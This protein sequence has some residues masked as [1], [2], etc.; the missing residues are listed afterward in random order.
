MSTTGA[1][2]RWFRDHFG[3]AEMAAEASGGQNAY[4][5]L[6]DLAAS[7]PAGSQGLVCLPYLSG[8]RTPI[9]DPLARGIYAGLTLSHTRAH[10]YRASLEGTAYGVRDNLDVMAAM[11]ADPK[12][13]VAVGGGA[14]NPLWL[15]IVSD[16]SG[17]AQMVPE[18]TIG[19]SY[20][21]AFLA[22]VATG[23]I[24]DRN[25]INT[26][27]V[28]IDRIVEPAP[29]MKPVYEPYYEIYRSLYRSTKTE[30]HQLAQLGQ[31]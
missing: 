12:R 29:S 7:V 13:I 28:T 20:G 14:S 4:Q 2:T 1:L 5:A 17:K 8:E 27:W 18:R 3:Q 30:M 10:L 19:A 31:Y 23:I 26:D 25:A 6:A 11:G 24:K 9:N 22:G 16:V 15:Q 21:D